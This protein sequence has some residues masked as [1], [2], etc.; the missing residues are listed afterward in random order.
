MCT[1]CAGVKEIAVE[2]PPEQTRELRHNFIQKVNFPLHVRAHAVTLY[3]Y[4]LLM[5]NNVEKCIK[6]TLL[7]FM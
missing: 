1:L 4:R 5:G 6:N 7:S 2:I 3:E